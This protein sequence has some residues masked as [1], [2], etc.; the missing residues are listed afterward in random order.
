MQIR[1]A[2]GLELYA[3]TAML[4]MSNLE[5]LQA[6]IYFEALHTPGE[7]QVQRLDGLVE[8]ASAACRPDGSPG[9]SAA[10]REEISSVFLEV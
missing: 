7:E 2:S 4:N 9:L 10:D 8:Q 1:I 6:A 3:S 5:C